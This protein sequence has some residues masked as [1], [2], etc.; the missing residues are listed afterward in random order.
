MSDE[1]RVRMLER[2]ANEHENVPGLIIERWWKT[3]PNPGKSKTAGHPVHDDCAWI[4]ITVP[5]D[6]NSYVERPATDVDDRRFPKS[7]AAL[8]SATKPSDVEGMP[9]EDWPQV[10]RGLAETLRALNIPTV[11]ALAAVNDANITNLGQPGRDLGSRHKP[12]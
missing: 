12:F 2:A 9:I 4:R 3:K 1:F 7:Y 6:K 11:E 5:G 10:T 8:M